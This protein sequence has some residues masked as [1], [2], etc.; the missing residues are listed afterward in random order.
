MNILRKNWRLSRRQFL[1]GAGISL[2]LPWLDAMANMPGSTP[3][4]A[5]FCMWGM[6]VNGRDFTPVETGSDY[7]LT[8]IL[9][10]LAEHKRDFTVISGLKLTHSGGHAGDR[11][12]LTGT[13]THKSAAKLR[14]S[15]DQELAAAIGQNTRYRSLVLG[16]R[17]GTGFGNNQDNTLSWT[18]NGTPIPAENRPHIL[19]D[20]LFRPDSPETIKEREAEFARRSSVLDSVLEEAKALNSALGKR[21][22]EKLDEYLT[23]IRDLEMSMK[24]EKSWLYKP[25][26]E[27]EPI[28]FGADQG[29][30]PSKGGLEYRRY[31]R[32]MFDV[33]T[34]ALQTDST[35]VVSYQPRMDNSD[36]TGAWKSEGNPYGYHTMTHHGE[37][38]DKL[39]WLTEVDILYMQEWAYFI[40]KLQSVKEGEGTL[41][42]HTMAVYG[43]T[44]GT[45]N[46]H[47]NHHLPALFCGGRRLGVQHRGHIEKE[48][49]YLGNLWRTMFEIMGV[50]TPENFQGGEAD[51][52]IQ[53]LI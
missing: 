43:S 29:L 15:C 40:D 42:D 17:R 4:R 45:I 36:G 3:K 1:H 5:V 21:D 33:I 41:L 8:P 52:S 11:T 18:R 26:P 19:F 53:E 14:V 37:D 20:R 34:L 6:G 25:K 48:E 38:S 51:G 7:K 44:G 50:P 10:P 31:Q 2:S 12:F 24:E 27:V 32:F 22:Q 16:I 23:G 46:A 30:D 35:R 13:N 49:D 39:K 28:D 9:E 47:H